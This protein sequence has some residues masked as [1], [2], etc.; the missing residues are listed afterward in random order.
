MT[1]PLDSDFER[2]GLTIL[3]HDYPMLSEEELLRFLKIVEEL[4]LKIYGRKN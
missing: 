2:E 4:M 3:R 1:K